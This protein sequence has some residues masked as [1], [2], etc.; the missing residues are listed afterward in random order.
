MKSGRELAVARTWCVRRYVGSLS[1]ARSRCCAARHCPS[2]RIIRFAAGILQEEG[3]S[4]LRERGRESVLNPQ[5][6][7][8]DELLYFCV[9]EHGRV[10]ATM[11]YRPSRGMFGSGIIEGRNGSIPSLRRSRKWSQWA[12][13]DSQ[14]IQVASTAL[15]AS[16]TMPW[17]LEATRT[18]R[19][20]F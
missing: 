20:L 17:G 2:R 16:R 19:G 3:T 7:F 6:S 10:C 4:L 14:A 8:F 12:K 18:S 9:A 1:S 11:A 5:E 13:P 15:S